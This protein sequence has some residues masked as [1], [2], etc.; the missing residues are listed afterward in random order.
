MSDEI[1][2]TGRDTDWTLGDTISMHLLENNAGHIWV[3][4]FIFYSDTPCLKCMMKAK[5]MFDISKVILQGTWS[6]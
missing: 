6:P 4:P 2:S 5:F 1:K 3:Y